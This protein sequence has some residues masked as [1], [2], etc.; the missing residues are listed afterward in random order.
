MGEN[1]S[2]NSSVPLTCVYQPPAAPK[3]LPPGS[4]SWADKAGV[5][6]CDGVAAE[7]L[8]AWNPLWDATE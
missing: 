1:Y 8:P 4:C 2:P 7:A 3:S 6:F 5:A